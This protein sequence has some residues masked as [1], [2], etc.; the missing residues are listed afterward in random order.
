MNNVRQIDSHKTQCLN[1]LM[2]YYLSQK[3][4]EG[5]VAELKKAFTVDLKQY[6]SSSYKTNLK[7]Q[8]HLILVKADQ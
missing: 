3:V 2:H 5:D 8:N 6:K 4:V 1:N 7:L